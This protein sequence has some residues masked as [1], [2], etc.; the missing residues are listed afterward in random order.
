MPMLLGDGSQCGQ[1]DWQLRWGGR[2][3]SWSQALSGLHWHVFREHVG[4]VVPGVA[5]QTLLQPLL[6][7]VVSW[8]DRRRKHWLIHAGKK[9]KKKKRTRAVH[10]YREMT[11]R[12]IPCCV[13][14]QRCHSERQFPQTHQLHPCGDVVGQQ[15]KELLLIWYKNSH[16]SRFQTLIWV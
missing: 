14:G 1:N 9:E 2:W 3:G 15:G 4:D 12:W 6:V 11:H 10:L 16:R 7:Q 5:I 8:G 13:P